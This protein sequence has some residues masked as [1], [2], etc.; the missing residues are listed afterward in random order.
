MKVIRENWDLD[1]LESDINNMKIGDS[2]TV[3]N[4]K[5]GDIYKFVK[6]GDHNTITDFEN[7]LGKNHLAS[8]QHVF[9]WAKDSLIYADYKPKFETAIEEDTVK[10]SDG[11]WT[12]KG[13]EGTHGKF[14]T[15]KAADAQRRAIWV[16]WNK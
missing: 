3:K 2:V 15:K 8:K 7:V 5:N 12:N 16:N 14:K 1:K 4:Y 11:K 13:D 6:R 9:G 10:T